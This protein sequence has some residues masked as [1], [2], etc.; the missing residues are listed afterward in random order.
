VKAIRVLA[1][2]SGVKIREK[3]LREAIEVCQLIHEAY[4]HNPNSHDRSAR[5]AV[6]AC[7]I[8]IENLMKPPV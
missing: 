8:G 1:E 4:G 7:I 3:A 5:A 2:A 6:Y